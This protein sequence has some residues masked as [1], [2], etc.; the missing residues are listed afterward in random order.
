MNFEIEI[1]ILT[2]SSEKWDLKKSMDPRFSYIFKQ[3]G[4]KCGNTMVTKRPGREGGVYEL[5]FFL[6]RDSGT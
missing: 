4:T 6:A 2:L 1:V 5:G 3:S